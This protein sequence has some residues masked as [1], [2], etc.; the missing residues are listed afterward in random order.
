MLVSCT[1]YR[2]IKLPNN[3]QEMLQKGDTVKITTKDGRE[4]KFK[5]TNVT[6]EAIISENQRVLFSEIARV[7]KRQISA[8]KTAALGGGILVGGFLAFVIGISIAIVILF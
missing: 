8:G 6:T 2:V 3:V 1:S 7:E 4:L 5:I